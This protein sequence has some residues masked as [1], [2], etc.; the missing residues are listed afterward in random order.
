MLELHV[1]LGLSYLHIEVLVFVHI[2]E[3]CWKVSHFSPTIGAEGLTRQNGMRSDPE[4]LYGRRATTPP[5]NLLTLHKL[6]ESFEK[7]SEKKKKA[8]FIRLHQ[9]NPVLEPSL[10]AFHVHYKMIVFSTLQI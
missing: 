1:N 8:H 10:P 4:H 9:I 6:P 3:K 7:V 2:L 5:T